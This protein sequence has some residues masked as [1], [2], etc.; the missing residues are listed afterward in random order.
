V[1]DG[2]ALTGLRVLDLGTGSG[3]VAGLLAHAGLDALG[4]DVRP[5]WQPLWAETRAHSALAG[6]L[7]LELADVATARWSDM[8]LVV[9]N[10]PFFAQRTG[11]VAPDPWRAAAR[12]ESTATLERFVQVGLAA[13]A[14]SGRLCVVVPVERA[15]EVREAAREAGAGVTRAVRVGRRRWLGELRPGHDDAED[16]LIDEEHPRARTWYALARRGSD[17]P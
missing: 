17:N 11:P 16:G 4:V 14:P 15:N 5:E 6:S 9:S 10:P 7:R 12:T 2:G 3:I 1:A 13:L 8:D